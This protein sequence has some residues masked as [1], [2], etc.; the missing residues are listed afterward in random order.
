MVRN[1]TTQAINT[2]HM[3][4]TAMKHYDGKSIE[5]LRCEDYMA[6]RKGPQAGGLNFG[7]ASQPSTSGLF[8]TSTTSTQSSIFGGNKSTTTSAPS[9]FGSQQNTSSSLFGSKKTGLF[10][11]TTTSTASP[12]GQTQQ[13]GTGLFGAKST[14][15]FRPDYE[16]EPSLKELEVLAERNGGVCHISDGFTVRRLAYGSVFWP[17]PFDLSNVDLDEVVVHFR[18]HEVTVYPDDEK[19]PPVGEGLNRFA[20]VSLERVWPLDKITKEII[21]DPVRIERCGFRAKLERCCASMGAKFKDYRPETGTWVF[22]VPH[23]TKYGFDFHCLCVL[24]EM[25]K[26]KDVL[27]RERLGDWLR[28]IVTSESAD[29]AATSNCSQI[30]CHL[31]SGELQKAVKD[32]IASKRYLLA[33]ALATFRKSRR[34]AYKKQIS[35]WVKSG[36]VEFI[37][38]NLLKIYLLMAGIST[39]KVKDHDVYV[40]EGLHWTQALGLYIW[41]YCNAETTIAEAWNILKSV[42]YGLIKLACDSEYSLASILEPTAFTEDC[43]DYHLSWHLLHILQSLGFKNILDVTQHA[44][45]IGYAEQLAE[46]DLN[47]FAVFVLMHIKDDSGYSIL[48]AY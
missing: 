41:Y 32:A 25:M 8:S 37:D 35:Y 24:D 3:C 29:G 19:K 39:V 43:F 2:K 1:G 10:G 20:E 27:Q 12:F 13:T 28:S 7:Q 17:G 48:F 4:I 5:E 23:F 45:H 16:C 34:S 6:N 11:S 40:I 31:C 14:T 22:S 15:C 9:L 46:L 26:S 18:Q 42:Y 47:N 33:I 36:A 38:E 30:F 44:I 21:K